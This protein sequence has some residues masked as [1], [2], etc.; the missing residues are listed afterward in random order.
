MKKMICKEDLQRF[1]TVVFKKGKEYQF[2]EYTAED[3]VIY[4]CIKTPTGDV[5]F[6]ERDLRRYFFGE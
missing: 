6:H 3:G 1:G 2:E 4:F 5:S